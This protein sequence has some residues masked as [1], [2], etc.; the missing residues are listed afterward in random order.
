[1]G[2]EFKL[3]LSKSI[4][5]TFPQLSHSEKKGH[6]FRTYTVSTMLTA[7]KL[8]V[9]CAEARRVLSVI[10]LTTLVTL[11]LFTDTMQNLKHWVSTSILPAL[12]MTVLS[13][14]KSILT[15]A[16]WTYLPC[17]SKD[18]SSSTCLNPNSVFAFL[19]PTCSFSHLLTLPRVRLFPSASRWKEK[20][21]LPL[22]SSFLSHFLHT[23]NHQ[24]SK[25][26]HFIVPLV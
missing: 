3:F 17:S 10:L 6:F 11:H 26:Y 18:I 19:S 5:Q 9:T 21:S 20:F 24:D 2:R 7:V 16:F 15:M 23:I 13:S 25:C 14:Y 22:T 4:I 1:M 12:K 8:A